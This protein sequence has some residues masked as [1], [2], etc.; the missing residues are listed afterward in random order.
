MMFHFRRKILPHNIFPKAF[1]LP[2][3]QDHLNNW[4]EQPFCSLS[5]CIW[6]KGHMELCSFLCHRM[7]L[8]T[9]PLSQSGVT[10]AFLRWTKPWKQSKLWTASC[11]YKCRTRGRASQAQPNPGCSHWH[12]G[13]PPPCRLQ[14]WAAGTAAKTRK[15]FHQD[16]LVLI[17]LWPGSS[18][19]LATRHWPSP[20]QE[21]L[22]RE[23]RAILSGAGKPLQVL[24]S[25]QNLNC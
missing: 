23:N 2:H 3:S 11:P 8:F 14:L 6:G 18:A 7:W 22:K 4:S 17:P 21:Q 13:N 20:W 1:F 5:S 10:W 24:V 19:T 9:H 12:W 25:I 16:S 15:G